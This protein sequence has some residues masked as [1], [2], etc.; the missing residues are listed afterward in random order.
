VVRNEQVVDCPP[1]LTEKEAAA[2]RA[3]KGNKSVLLQTWATRLAAEGYEKRGIEPETSCAM[4][5]LGNGI[6]AL[7]AHGGFITN[8]VAL[9]IP[10]PY[11]HMLVLIM[12]VNYAFFAVAFL[13]MDAYI[14]PMIMFLTVLLLSAFRE[15]SI[16][17]V[18]PFGHDEVDFPVSKY[19]TDLRAGMGPL[20]HDS[21]PW[22]DTL[23]PPE[24]A[25]PF[26]VEVGSAA[27][28]S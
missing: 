12:I 17:L 20:A 21:P 6:L 8:T 4:A 25:L 22:P 11:W 19:I 5:G 13:D 23:A 2:L 24:K 14:T 15:M 3:Y 7:K 26:A 1:L 27:A 16:Q 28:A 10:Y 18:N 9:P